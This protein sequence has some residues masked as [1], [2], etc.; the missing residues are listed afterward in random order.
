MYDLPPDF[1]PRIF[2]GAVLTL[3]AFGVGTIHLT[4][5]LASA[6]SSAQC[7]PVEIVVQSPLKLTTSND[8]HLIRRGDYAEIARLG[9]L[10]NGDVTSASV[11]GKRCLRLEF[12]GVGSV[13]I[14]DDD[15]G[16]ECY[17]IYGIGADAIF[18]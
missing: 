9:A 12:G 2:E 13:Q 16:Y 5:Q 10:L 11:C 6:R 8:Q 1:D 3:V 7:K 14:D 15:S 18:V 4:F 17:A